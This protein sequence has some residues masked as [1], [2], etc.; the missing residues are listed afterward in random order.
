MRA[1]EL[2]FTFIIIV[3]IIYT[4]IPCALSVYCFVILPHMH[5]D[6]VFVEDTTVTGVETVVE[7][8]I[9]Q[10]VPLYTNATPQP[11]TIAQLR[12]ALQVCNPP[13]P[14]SK[15]YD[16]SELSA[17]TEYYL[18]SIGFN[19]TISASFTE[20]HAWCTVCNIIGYDIVHVECVPPTHISERLPPV[21][22][23]YEDIHDALAGDYP[24]EWDWF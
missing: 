17:C 20:G 22:L 16:C 13:Q 3:G 23:S 7:I 24:H 6:D 9:H 10:P 15:S 5:N 21:E 12:T 19:T 11:K 18:E 4:A 8:D 14:Y 1:I 2:I